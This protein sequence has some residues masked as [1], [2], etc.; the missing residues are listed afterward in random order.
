MAS[1]FVT[2]AD[3]VTSNHNDHLTTDHS[4]HLVIVI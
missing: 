2:V 4:D 1:P 3:L